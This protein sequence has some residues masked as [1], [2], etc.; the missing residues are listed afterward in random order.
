MVGEECTKMRHMLEIN[1][2]MDNGI[3]KNWED[4]CHLWDYTFGSEK[5]DIDP[6]V[7][8]F[9]NLIFYF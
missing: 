5:L 9:F 3:V 2:P 8:F 6:K 7:Y 4:M 1:Y